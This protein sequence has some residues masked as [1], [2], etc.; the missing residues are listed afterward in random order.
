[1]VVG[2]IIIIIHRLIIRNG[3][4]A[5]HGHADGRRAWQ[6]VDR[7][8]NHGQVTDFISVGNFAVFNIADASIS[9]VWWFC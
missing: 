2:L 4:K 7:L 5:G 1:V 9:M 3:A 6:R 8:T